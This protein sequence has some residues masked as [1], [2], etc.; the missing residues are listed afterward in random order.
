MSR[1]RWTRILGQ[2]YARWPSIHS[3]PRSKAMANKGVEPNS[4][5]ETVTGVLT[6][7]DWALWG[8]LAM[9]AIYSMLRMATERSGPEGRGLGGLAALLLLVLLA[10]TAW[11]VSVAARRQSL[12]GLITMAV[13]MAWPLIALIADPLIKAKR[14]RGYAAADA[15]V[16]DFK[17]A[18]LASM[19]R[20]IA[21]NDTAT[22]TRL[23]DGQRPPAGKDRAGNDLL[24]YALVLVRDRAGSAAP[25][26]VLLEAGADARETRIGGDDV[27]TYYGP[28]SHSRCA[29][30]DAIAPRAWSRP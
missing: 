9:L 11:G 14:A 22:L 28:R 27:V 6:K 25:V 7:V 26:R 13:I 15:S 12:T 10:G 21:Q 19:A 8:L 1:P 18:A 30:G 20:A 3:D 29:R 24:G 2:R 4:N 23:L 17:D 16:G 5:R